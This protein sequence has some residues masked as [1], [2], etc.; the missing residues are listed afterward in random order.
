ML[1]HW[2]EMGHAALTPARAFAEQLRCLVENPFNPL[3]HTTAG[4]HASA[5]FEVF[6]RT[7]RRYARPVF[8]LEKTRVGRR[9]I[10]VT[11]EVVWDRPFC[12]LVHFRRDMPQA[13]R[14]ADPRVLL[15]APMSG[16]YATLL[17]GTVEALLPNH[18]VFITDWQEIGRA[19]V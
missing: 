6:E 4:R 10:A 5:A 15:I 17:R 9:E 12:R 1:Y 2:Y 11:E 14:A 3:S 19:H 7:T 18:E 8:G 16:H 13:Q